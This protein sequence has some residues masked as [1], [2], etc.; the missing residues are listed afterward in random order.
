MLTKI[1]SCPF[2]PLPD[3]LACCSMWLDS[4]PSVVVSIRSVT[5]RR[6]AGIAVSEASA[7]D[8]FG[9]PAATAPHA[10]VSVCAP[11][12]VLAVISLT[13]RSL[14]W[15]SRITAEGPVCA[16]LTG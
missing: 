16:A 4:V 14:R 12:K 15:N 2:C 11:S 1:S 8:R 13:S 7:A 5:I 6:K 10:R 9:A 3:P